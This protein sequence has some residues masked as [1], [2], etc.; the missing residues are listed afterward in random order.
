VCFACDNLFI[1]PFRLFMHCNLDS[2]FSTGAGVS[3]N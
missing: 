1:F 2:V 3:K